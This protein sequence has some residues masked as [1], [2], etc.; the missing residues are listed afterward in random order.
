MRTMDFE[1]CKLQAG[2]I[3]AAVDVWVRSRWQAQPWLEQRM[4]YTADQNLGFFRTVVAVEN[5]VWIAVHHEMVLGVMAIGDGEIDQLYVGPEYQNRGI[6]T[7]LLEKARELQPGGLGLFT[8]QKNEK[9]RRFYQR[10]GFVAVRF[11]VS[12][13]PESEPDVRYEWTPGRGQT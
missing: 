1:V 12:P 7:A 10:K 6:G 8:H 3:E 4:D 13:A 5:D 2:Q 11:G 9:A